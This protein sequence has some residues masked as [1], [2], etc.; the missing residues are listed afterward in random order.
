[1]RFSTAVSYAVIYEKPVLV[2][3]ND[4]IQKNAD[5]YYRRLH[6]Y[7]EMLNVN[8]VNVDKLPTLLAPHLRAPR[9]AYNHYKENY[10]TS[11]YDNLKPNHRIIVEDVLGLNPKHSG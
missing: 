5:F 2:I 10:L 1:M 7:A 3:Y 4:E 8:I 9:E 6:N 11:L